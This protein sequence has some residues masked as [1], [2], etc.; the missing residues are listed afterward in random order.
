MSTI[1]QTDR[2]AVGDLNKDGRDDV[3]WYRP[4]TEPDEVWLANGSGGFAVSRAEAT[5]RKCCIVAFG[6]R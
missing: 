6:F 1:H 3:F 2:P 5:S 4:G